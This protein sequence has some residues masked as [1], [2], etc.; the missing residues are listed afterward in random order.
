[1]S[2]GASRF[3]GVRT[4]TPNFAVPRAPRISS[5]HHVPLS[6][7]RSDTKQSVSMTFLDERRQQVCDGLRSRT[8][9]ADEDLFFSRHAQWSPQE[10][11]P[12]KLDHVTESTA[13]RSHEARRL[14]G[15]LPRQIRCSEGRLGRR[16]PPRGHRWHLLPRLVGRPRPGGD[17]ERHRGRGHRPQPRPRTTNSLPPSRSSTPR[18]RRPRSATQT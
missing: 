10:T 6:T 2:Q 17:R 15:S 7:S 12:V 13:R 8:R 3:S 11:P 14:P 1:M 18:W 16:E 9:P 5:S 4:T